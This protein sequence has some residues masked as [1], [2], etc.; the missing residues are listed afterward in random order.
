[1]GRWEFYRH[2]HAAC[3]KTPK[4]MIM[5]NLNVHNTFP[6]ASCVWG[7]FTVSTA[8]NIWTK[9]IQ[10]KWRYT[11]GKLAEE[12]CQYLQP[13]RLHSRVPAGEDNQK[14]INFFD[15]FEN[16][17][18]GTQ[19]KIW[20]HIKSEIWRLHITIHRTWEIIIVYKLYY[21][22]ANMDTNPCKCTTERLLKMKFL[23]VR[24]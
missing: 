18:L 2:N 20:T 10:R 15:P 9:E 17:H 5:C 13:N 1:M 21:V 8:E 12:K 7:L 4:P 16:K 23:N 14:Q 22:I 24:E 6:S 3:L 19:G 11:W